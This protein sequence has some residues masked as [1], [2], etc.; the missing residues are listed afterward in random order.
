VRE[1]DY[2]ALEDKRSERGALP[3]MPR[4][5]ANSGAEGVG[6]GGRFWEQVGFLYKTGEDVIA[7]PFAA[8]SAIPAATSTLR[9]MTDVRFEV[10]E[11]VAERCTGCGQCWVQ[12]P[13]AAIPGLVNTIDEILE[14]TVAAQSNGRTFDRFRPV[15]R[16]LAREAQRLLAGPIRSIPE[17]LTQAYQGVVERMGMDPERRAATDAEFSVIH[18]AVA[19]FPLA[20][21]APFFEVPEGKQKGTGGLLSITVNPEACKGCNICVDVCPDQALITIRQDDQV[22]DRLRRNWE[23]W[24]QLPDTNDRYVNVRNLEEGIG[25]LT[26]LLLKK[27]NY[28]SMFGGDGAC[29]GC[30]EKTAIHLVFCA[31]NALMYPRVARQVER[32]ADLMARLDRKAREL[33]AADADLDR[34]EAVELAP[35]KRAA[36]ERIAG[37]LRD[38]KDLRW[39]YTEGPSRRGR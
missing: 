25:V 9:D 24:Q 26:S 13:D 29:M 28:T 30:G 3:V 38:L 33:V 36:V 6:Q 35:D 16:P 12:C 21:T 37:M 4:A 8:I 15:L 39:R 18:A 32:L 27:D 19:A 20:K 5:L 10:P 2:S 14:A 31:V 23:L 1:V 11:F 17:A 7:D 22:V 34:L